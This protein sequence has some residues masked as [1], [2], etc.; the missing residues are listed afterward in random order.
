[1]ASGLGRVVAV[2]PSF[3]RNQLC[4]VLPLI[5]RGQGSGRSAWNPAGSWWF[6]CGPFVGMYPESGGHEGGQ[7]G[8][9]EGAGEQWCGHSKGH[10]GAHGEF[11]TGMGLQSCP[12]LRRGTQA[13]GS[14]LHTS[15]HQ[16]C[17][18]DAVEKRYDLGEVTLFSWGQCQE[19]GLAESWKLPNS[20]GQGNENCSPEEGIWAGCWEYATPWF[21]YISVVPQGSSGGLL[22]KAHSWAPSPGF[23]VH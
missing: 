7:Q 12:E 18:R 8:W 9:A 10:H 15:T 5:Q 6:A 19:R 14:S 4:T 13:F 17:M 16:P 1:M 22:Q 11:G 23:L 21:P 2:A 3:S 20:Q